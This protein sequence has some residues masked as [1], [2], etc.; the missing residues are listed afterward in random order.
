MTKDE[1]RDFIAVDFETATADRFA[2]QVGIVVVKER[3]V[4][5][6][7]V[8]LIQPPGNKYDR[9]CMAVH[10]ITP[11]VTDDAPTFKE[12]WEDIEPYFRNYTVVMHN[13]EFD[14]DVLHR[15]L[16]YYGIDST[17]YRSAFCTYRMF[18]RSLATLCAGYDMDCSGHHD[19]EF[20]AMCCAQFFLHWLRDEEPDEMKMEEA[21]NKKEK[22]KDDESLHGN[23]LVKDLTGA[24]PNN[25]FYDKRVVVTGVFPI[26]R[27]EMGD[28]LKAYGAD[29]N[30]SISKLTDY[31]L[32]GYDAGPKK[33]E[34]I[35]KLQ[36]EGYAIRC[37]DWDAVSSMF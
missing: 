36:E 2:C 17:P 9:M 18:G 7:I 29:I 34:K 4:V 20:D 16:T 5:E 37:L 19:A 22:K 14:L 26:P 13:A 15:N 8:R 21:E 35:K 27:K 31:V 30:T 1:L 25:I 33:L 10:H 12:V 32:V 24:D 23:V 6:K 11:Y 3:K 28:K